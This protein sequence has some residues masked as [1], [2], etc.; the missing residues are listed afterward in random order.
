MDE[1]PLFDTPPYQRHSRTSRDAAEQARESAPTQRQRVF[2][3]LQAHD[4]T[5][6]EM[7]CALGMNPSTQRPRRIELHRMGFVK[8]SG[9][10]RLTK[11]G[12]KAVVWEATEFVLKVIAELE[13]ECLRWN[14]GHPIGTEVIYHPV[15]GEAKGTKTKTRTIAYVMSGHTAVLF[16]EGHAGCVALDA[17][18]EAEES[19]DTVR[20]G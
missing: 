18:E 20:L 19:D 5:D 11:S 6:E 2:A 16:V 14:A 17:I 10:K 4:A 7:Q 8:D 12:R 15:I 13:A 3:Q 1:L 9:R